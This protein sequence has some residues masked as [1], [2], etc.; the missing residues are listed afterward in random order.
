MIKKSYYQGTEQPTPGKNQYSSD[1]AIVIQPRFKEPFY[2]NFDLYQTEGVDSMS[3]LEPGTGWSNINKYKSI[4]DFIDN[5]NL[6]D[7]YVAEDNWIEDNW[8]NYQQRIEKMK[9]R[10]N[11]LYNLIKV[12]QINNFKNNLDLAFNSVSQWRFKQDNNNI[13]FEADQYSDTDIEEGSHEFMMDDLID[14]GGIFTLPLPE[15]DFEGKDPTQLDFGRDYVEDQSSDLTDQ[16][17]QAFTDKYLTPGSDGIFGLPDGVNPQE[18]NLES[19]NINPEFGTVDNGL[20]MYE[21][22]WNI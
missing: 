16:Q 18:D 10:A 22:K 6:A 8:K 9:T 1:S 20:N 11:K 15:N 13:D 4:N 2:K 12:A 21:D 5:K 7:K 19:E 14:G 17:L 3:K